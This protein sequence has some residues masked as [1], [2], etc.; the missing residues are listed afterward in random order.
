MT[1]IFGFE[2]ILCVKSNN[3][4]AKK[5]SVIYTITI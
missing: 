4:N 5:Q 2:E 1:F 3:I